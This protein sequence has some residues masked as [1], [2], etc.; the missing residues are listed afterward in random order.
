VLIGAGV[1]V[2]V[3]EAVVL[4]VGLW[5]FGY[6]RSKVLDVNKAQAGV[7][8]ILSDP[9]NGYGRN[10]V[11]GVTCNNG[12]N[13]VV[14]KDASFTCAVTVNGVQRKV[15]VVFAD[16]NGTYEVGRPK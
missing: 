16:D 2:V 6:F 10:D 12:R 11:T 3:V 14:S 13:P 5:H 15:L 7:A 1:A 8:Q 9:V 4:V